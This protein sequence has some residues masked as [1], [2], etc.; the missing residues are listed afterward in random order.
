METGPSTVEQEA[1][2]SPMARGREWLD[3]H[4]QRLQESLAAQLA[5]LWE[6]GD[7]DFFRLALTQV[8]GRK[9]EE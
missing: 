4:D 3:S 2:F 5:R 1:Q 9:V 6:A 8:T 7:T